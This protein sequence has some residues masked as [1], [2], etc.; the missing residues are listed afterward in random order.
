MNRRPPIPRTA[1]S[2]NGGPGG[3]ASVLLD[4]LG[5]LVRLQIELVLAEVRELAR[6]LAVT[7]AVGLAS[8][9]VLLASLITLVAG[10]LAPIFG[11]E[12]AH[13]LVAGGAFGS[14][15]VAGGWWTIV[16]LRGVTWPTIALQSLEETGQWLGIQLR[17][18]LTLP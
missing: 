14:L 7:L 6:A 17:S 13:L 11:A 18:G 1:T 12:P 9:V 2:S 15:A 5:Q 16:R 10:A 8:L 4:R 3:H